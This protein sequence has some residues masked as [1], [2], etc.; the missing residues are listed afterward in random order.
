MFV[1]RQNLYYYNGDSIM[2]GDFK[3]IYVTSC[4]VL[5][6]GGIGF[7]KIENI[8]PSSV[9]QQFCSTDT[10]KPK[11]QDL[12]ELMRYQALCEYKHPLLTDSVGIPL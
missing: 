9:W 2:N 8:I 12:A 4:C 3:S 7:L 5:N 11:S 6:T 1:K 10:N